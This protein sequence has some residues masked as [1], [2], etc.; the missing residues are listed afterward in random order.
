MNAQTEND[1]R[2]KAAENSKR[3]ER[4]YLHEL[5]KALGIEN[6]QAAKVQ[7]TQQAKRMLEVQ[8][9]LNCCWGSLTGDTVF[10]PFTECM[11]HDSVFRAA[12]YGKGVE[13]EGNTD[14]DTSRKTAVGQT[15]TNRQGECME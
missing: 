15:E 6:L 5:L 12:L 3:G 10:C 1:A 2:K 13:S 14:G 4:S 11:K 8:K 9:C 7:N